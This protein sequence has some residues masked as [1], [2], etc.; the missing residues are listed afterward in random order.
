MEYALVAVIALLASGLT[1]YSGFG[2]GTLLLPVFALF[3]PIEVAV[4][5]TALV[6]GANSIFK[7]A[8]LGK[9]A[10]PSVVLRFGV[11]ALIASFFGAIALSYVSHFSELFTYTIGSHVAV[12]TPIKMSI[13]LLMLGF[14]A[15][16][17]FPSL[18]KVKIDS[19]YLPIGGLL[20][21]FFGGFSGHQGALR[22]AFL[23]KIET[24]A[25][26]F[27][28]TGAII[29]A[30]VDIV[31]ISTY[32]YILFLGKTTVNIQME[33]WAL[34]LIAII[35]AFCG[36][37]IGRRW[38]QKITIGVIQVITGLLLTGISLGLIFGII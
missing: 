1:L 22:S 17:L 25:Q 20:S 5:A 8:V 24:T 13:G 23:A 32:G 28:G 35:S 7:A 29:A 36:V 4:A 12:V 34:I 26:G 3:M 37:I 33:Q 2:L 31:R 9:H 6:H 15:F 21:G 19:K 10:N 27:V 11:P 14:A 18:K 30:M 16:E 38:L